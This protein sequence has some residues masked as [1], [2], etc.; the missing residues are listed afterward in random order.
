MARPRPRPITPPRRRQASGSPP[1]VLLPVRKTEWRVGLN[2]SHFILCARVGVW[3]LTL[4][5]A[6]VFGPRPRI[7]ELLFGIF[8]PLVVLVPYAAVTFVVAWLRVLLLPAPRPWRAE[9]FHEARE[10]QQPGI[11]R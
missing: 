11:S 9:T 6:L 1:P 10:E 7:D 5:M 2:R 3:W 8:L 4:V